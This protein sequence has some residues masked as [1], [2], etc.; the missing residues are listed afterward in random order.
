LEK[1]E[2]LTRFKSLATRQIQML[3]DKVFPNFWKIMNAIM[4]G[5]YTPLEYSGPKKP[6]LALKGLRTY[7]SLVSLSV[8]VRLS[9]VFWMD[10]AVCNWD[11]VF[12]T[13]F[14]VDFFDL[15]IVK[16]LLNDP[17]EYLSLLVHYT[18]VRNITRCGILSSLLFFSRVRPLSLTYSSR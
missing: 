9:A 6:S 3:G 17:S 10:P 2:R 15:A 5:E 14:L 1:R 8:S 11:F 13:G 16:Y 7:F 12:L 18:V 4:K